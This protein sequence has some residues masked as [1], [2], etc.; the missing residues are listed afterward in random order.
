MQISEQ[1]LNCTDLFQSRL[2]MYE[3]EDYHGGGGGG[4]HTQGE[5]ADTER[6]R[7][8]RSASLTS[9]RSHHSRHR[10]L[11]R[12]DSSQS[13]GFTVIQRANQKANIAAKSPV[14]SFRNNAS[15]YGNYELTP[16]FIF[17]KDTVDH[18]SQKLQ[19]KAHNTGRA[20]ILN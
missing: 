17:D 18:Y 7:L 12:S 19:L 16:I 1:L 14:I 2:I 5:E 8:K 11:T 3:A 6:A 9:H 4:H 15:K 20:L 10:E 13:E